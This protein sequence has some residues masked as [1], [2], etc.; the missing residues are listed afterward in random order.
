M[1]NAR[2]KVWNFIK[3]IWSLKPVLLPVLVTL[4]PLPL[5]TNSESK[6]TRCGYTVIVMA[7]LWLTEALPI[8]VTSLV[9]I[10]MLPMLGVSTAKEVS[11]SYVTVR[12]NP[13][14]GTGIN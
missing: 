6:A 10:F 4:L 1:A 11:S 2:T 5:V 13:W 3:D 7:V 12:T 8:P 9:P 14:P